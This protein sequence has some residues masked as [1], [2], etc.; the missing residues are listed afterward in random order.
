MFD[1]PEEEEDGSAV[2]DS[3]H[4]VVVIH[5]GFD[6]I[7]KTWMELLSLVEDEQRLRAAQHRVSDGVSQMALRIEKNSKLTVKK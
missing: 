2:A 1:Q 3:I 6:G 5:E 7:N 4:V